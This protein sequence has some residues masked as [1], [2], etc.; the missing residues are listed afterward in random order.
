MS[1]TGNMEETMSFVE[2]TAI[3]TGAGSGIGRATAA[4]LS[5]RGATVIGL[6]RDRERVHA[7]VARIC[8][9]GGRAY[10]WA[11]D[12]TEPVQVGACV[13]AV[14]R[15]FGR[16]DILV[17]GV[18]GS[19]AIA[20]PN[21]AVAD[22]SLSEWHRLLTLNLDGTFLLCHEIA[23]IMISQGRGKIVNIGSIAARGLARYSNAAYAAA[24]GGI[25]AMTKQLAQELGPHGINVNAVSPGVTLT[26]R[27][28]ARWRA[29]SAAERAHEIA[30]IPLRRIARAEDQAGV[31]CF[32]ASAE[33]D[34][35]TGET[36][37]VTGG[38]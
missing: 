3:V 7:A 6:D 31:I 2:Q 30:R 9:N 18:G 24:K 5:R 13:A 20:D 23:P 22:L 10:A 37:E 19:T 16:I 4:E 26:E 8:D 1:R 12:V 34:F 25:V 38:L 36:V 28:G 15:E 29:R 33:A 27:I 14:M 21:A 17:N 11:V 32:L 35:I